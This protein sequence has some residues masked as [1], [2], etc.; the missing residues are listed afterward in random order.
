MSVSPGG[1]A[2]NLETWAQGGLVREYANR[3]LRP[4]EAQILERYREQ[5]SG[6]VLEIGCGGG[7]LSGYLAE[8]AAELHAIDISPEMVE[9]CRAVYPGA[10]FAIGDMRDLSEH[11]DDSFEVVFAGSNVLDAVG[12][13]DRERSL[14]EFK[15][16]LAPGGLFVLSTHNLAAAAEVRGPAG[17]LLVCARAGDARGLARAIVRFPKR[18]RNHRRLGPLESTGQGEALVNDRAHDY[19]LLHFY[20]SPQRQAQQLAEHGFGLIEC[21]DRDGAAVDPVAGESESPDLHYVATGLAAPH[22]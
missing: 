7:R 17:D 2:D 9:H 6:R 13:A 4:V 8:I 11:A 5:L 16:V 21:L 15:R 1:A 19:S 14:G 22:A 10:S 18:V 12:A 20:I 3:E